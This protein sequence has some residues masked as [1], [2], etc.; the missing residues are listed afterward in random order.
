MKFI[1]VFVLTY[2]ILT[3]TYKVYLD[4]STGRQYYPD[5]LTNLVAKQS[6]NLLN[7][8]G[9]QTVIEAHANE[10]SVKMIIRDKFVARIVEGCNAASVTIL[11]ASFI[12]A[13]STQLKI[14]AFY[15]LFGS[16]ILYVTNLIRIVV[17]SIGLYHYPWRR[18][19]L[20]T[21][22]FPLIIYG[23]VFLLWMFW[24]NYFTFKQNDSK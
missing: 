15:I 12:L 4:E 8:V 5:Y 2:S 19:I 18:D 24:V 7:S 22:I 3:L 11:F 20:H 17:L 23:I 16:V 6:A 14:T 13:F 21:I 9:Y 1:I 10:P